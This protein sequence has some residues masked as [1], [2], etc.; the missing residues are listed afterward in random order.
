MQTLKGMSE[1]LW[2]QTLLCIYGADQYTVT[3]DFPLSFTAHLPE[4]KKKKNG[5]FLKTTPN[6][7][8]IF[9]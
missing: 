2:N 7:T 6:K 4:E 8:S 1:G 9:V 3:Q 5:V